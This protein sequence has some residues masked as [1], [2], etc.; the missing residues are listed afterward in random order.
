[1]VDR[2]SRLSVWKLLV[3]GIIGLVWLSLIMLTALGVATILRPS[4]A[5]RNAGP[6]GRGFGRAHRPRVVDRDV[7]YEDTP[8]AL[9]QRRESDIMEPLPVTTVESS[10]DTEVTALHESPP[11]EQP[12]PA[13]PTEPEPAPDSPSVN[14]D[15]EHWV[16]SEDAPESES[17]PRDVI[18]DEGAEAAAAKAETERPDDGLSLIHI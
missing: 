8:R 15:P 10:D 4:R 6:I 7:E 2:L 13:A 14:E 16:D 17:G 12:P 18:E 5:R 11:E 1:M 3:V 9:A